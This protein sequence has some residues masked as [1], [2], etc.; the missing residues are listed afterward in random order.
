MVFLGES[1]SFQVL[2]FVQI[3]IVVGDP[4]IKRKGLISR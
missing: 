4:D 3:G 1:E 2:L